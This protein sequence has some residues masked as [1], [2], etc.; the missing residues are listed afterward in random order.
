MC[1]SA[2]GQEEHCWSGVCLLLRREVGNIHTC[3]C[4][5]GNAEPCCQAEPRCRQCTAKYTAAITAECATCSKVQTRRYLACE[6]TRVAGGTSRS[7]VQMC[8]VSFQCTATIGISFRLR[9]ATHTGRTAIHIC[10]CASLRR[11][12]AVI[13][14]SSNRVIWE[15]L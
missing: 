7:Q 3:T 13:A 5:A 6:Y 14:A 4:T 15:T 11:V 8:N 2:Y 10:A 9:H 1:G 12:C